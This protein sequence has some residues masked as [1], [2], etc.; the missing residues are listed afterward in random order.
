MNDKDWEYVQNAITSLDT[1]VD[2]NIVIPSH[3][4]AVQFRGQSPTHYRYETIQR[5]ELKE[6]KN[7]PEVFLANQK[8]F[9][10]MFGANVLQTCTCGHEEV[11][12]GAVPEFMVQP[13]LKKLKKFLNAQF[14][15]T[16]MVSVY[17]RR[18]LRDCTKGFY[19]PPPT[20]VTRAFRW[21]WSL[22][23]S[24]NFGA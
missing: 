1:S 9:A 6:R 19:T 17:V 2:L 7:S 13:L 4:L 14:G 23:P 22:F 12:G 8:Y 3:K 10:Q 16:S 24:T 20:R 5:F 18:D 11:V 15:S 21:F